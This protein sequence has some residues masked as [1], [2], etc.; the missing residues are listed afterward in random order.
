MKTSD[1]MKRW[2]E[3]GEKIKGSCSESDGINGDARFEQVM[4]AISKNWKQF[5]VS[6]KHHKKSKSRS[7][8][9]SKL[10]TTQI[11]DC[12]KSDQE[13]NLPADAHEYSKKMEKRNKKKPKK[14]LDISALR[15]FKTKGINMPREE[16]EAAI[17]DLGL[18]PRKVLSGT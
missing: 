17:R 5:K 2:A 18:D 16:I 9:F 11:E 10:D 4:D 8:K 13:V 1:Q 3:L 14:G 7:A 15:N 6:S 12:L